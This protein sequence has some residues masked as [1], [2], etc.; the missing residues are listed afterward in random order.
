MGRNPARARYNFIDLFAGAGGLSEGFI[1]AG[2]A[3]VAHVEMNPFAA[4]T[5]ETRTAYYWLKSQGQLSR[6]YDYLRGTIT[7]DELLSAIPEEC[8]KSVLCET[9]SVETLP[10][11]FKTID[12]LLAAIKKAL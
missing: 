12:E 6:Y 9:M 3:P 11:I 4:K 10:G 7:R 1:Q 8:L 2:F 5:L